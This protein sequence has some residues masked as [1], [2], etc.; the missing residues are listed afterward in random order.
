MSVAGAPDLLIDL[1]TEAAR[2]PGGQVGLLRAGQ[3]AEIL[4]RHRDWVQTHATQLGGFRLPGSEEW[5]FAPRGVANGIFGLGDA[6]GQPLDSSTSASSRPRAS[7]RQLAYPPARQVLAD[8]PRQT[9]RQGGSH[10]SPD[11]RDD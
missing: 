3:V 10:A 4:G 7:T 1:L 9:D 11:P 6:A 5:R 8:R 2:T